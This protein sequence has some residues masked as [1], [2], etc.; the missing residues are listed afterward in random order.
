[1][2]KE[3][4]LV[5]DS[6]PFDLLVVAARLRGS[7]YTVQI[8]SSAEQALT[9][10]KTLRPELML[11]ATRLPAMDGFDLAGKIRK[12]SQ[13]HGMVAVA[14]LPSGAAGDGAKAIEAG[15]QAY[16]VKPVDSVELV[17]RVKEYLALRAQPQEGGGV[18]VPPELL[19]DPE[20]EGLRRN[21]L[22][23][24]SRNFRGLLDT[25]ETQFDVGRAGQFAGQ[26]AASAAHLG[27]PALAAAARELHT[28]LSVE[29]FD[30]GRLR[31]VMRQLQE[32]FAGQEA[33][34]AAVPSGILG[35]LAGKRMALVGF[36]DREAERICS[37]IERAQA[38]AWLLDANEA[39]DS[40]AVRA[41]DAV[42]VHVRPETA[43]SGWLRGDLETAGLPML[44]LVGARD[45]I[46]ALEPAVQA[47]AQEFLIDGWQPEEV[48]LRLSL[49]L[50]RQRSAPP[51]SQATAVAAPAAAP[52][53]K[54]LTVLIADDDVDI[55]IL[56]SAILGN[57]G[58]K[59]HTATH[60]AEAMEMMTKDPPDAVVLDVNMPGMDGFEVLA[61]MREVG[62]T[63]PAVLLTARQQE[64]DI[65][66][67]FS[68][69][70]K[71]YVVKPFSPM[72]LLARLRR[73]IA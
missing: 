63:I 42:L 2:A 9:M 35:E 60:G 64:M 62:S 30:K 46:L 15:Y 19:S 11:A 34:A 13:L 45:S 14:L 25:L 50:S 70:A 43:G 27:F 5:V 58:I 12:D 57:H 4:V 66:R 71:D 69:G 39:T 56:V 48:I 33:E 67:A 49:A 36:A 6:D 72:E 28:L 54:S 53:R 38:E 20:M 73:L 41:C 17:S 29:S 24:G 44:V 18:P 1:V 37:A 8:V 47:R 10:L 68:L 51:A 3:T 21:F 26:W 55:R 52:A 40:E 32:A 31:E 7:G 16:L 61:K 59:V 22:A 65:L 23:D